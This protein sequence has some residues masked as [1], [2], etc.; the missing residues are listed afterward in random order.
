MVS[1]GR[2]QHSPRS[3]RPVDTARSISVNIQFW[4][5]PSF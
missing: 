5:R 3:D 1:S 2:F 4:V